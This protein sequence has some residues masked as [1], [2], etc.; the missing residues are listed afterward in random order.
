MWFD[1]GN[2]AL[3]N[4]VMGLQGP[5]M[6]GSLIDLIRFA[7]VSHRFSRMFIDFH[8]CS[9]SFSD[10]QQFP[11]VHE[12]AL[13]NSRFSKICLGFSYISDK[14]HRFPLICTDVRRCSRCLIDVE[15]CSS[16]SIYCHYVSS[17]VNDVD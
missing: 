3:S 8:R 17:I 2:A 4:D 6:A 16:N 7:F 1:A 5:L 14:L 10:F 12:R 15:S 9:M 11:L 13:T